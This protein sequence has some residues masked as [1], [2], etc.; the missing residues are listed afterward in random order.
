MKIITTLALDQLI[1]IPAN[2]FNFRF[3]AA[4][5]QGLY[6]G[7]FNVIYSVGL[8]YIAH[9]DMTRIWEDCMQNIKQNKQI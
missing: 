5:Y 8:S 3:V 4:A 1:W 2:G 9:H 7:F 6:V